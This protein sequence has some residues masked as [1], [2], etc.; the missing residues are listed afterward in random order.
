MKTSVQH[1]IPNQSMHLDLAFTGCVEEDAIVRSKLSADG[2]HTVPVL[3][4]KLSTFS[5]TPR[6]MLIEQPFTELTRPQC[7]AKAKE[8]IKGRCI[9][10]NSSVDDLRLVFP[11][12]QQIHIL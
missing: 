9:T 12:V 6:R 4:I 10:F 3:C 2:L 5:A 11:N 7:E 8:L 1:G